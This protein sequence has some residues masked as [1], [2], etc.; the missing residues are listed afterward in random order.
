MKAKVIG[1]A[2][3]IPP[4][5]RSYLQAYGLVSNYWVEVLCHSPVTIV[6]IDNIELALENDLARGIKVEWGADL[7]E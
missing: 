6:R 4:D 5:R 3:D 2:A 7:A 1:F